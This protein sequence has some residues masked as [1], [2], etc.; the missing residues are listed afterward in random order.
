MIWSIVQGPIA[1]WSSRYHSH[2]QQ[3][4]LKKSSINIYTYYLRTN[5]SCGLQKLS[6]K[7]STC[8]E[9]IIIHFFKIK[10]H[11]VLVFGWAFWPHDVLIS[12]LCKFF[13]GLLEKVYNIFNYVYMWYI[14]H[15]FLNL[16][17]C[18]SCRFKKREKYWLLSPALSIEWYI[19]METGAE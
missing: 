16:G 8:T 12:S 9:N 10:A 11:A 18:K 1:A 17:S 15:G 5:S 3:L 7:L 19:K 13:F 14:C 6:G 2:M 4:L